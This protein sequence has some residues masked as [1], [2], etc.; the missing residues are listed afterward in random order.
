MNER[1][2]KIVSIAVIGLI[3]IGVAVAVGFA[4]RGGSSPSP[5]ASSTSW[6]QAAA[7]PDSNS[8]DFK[9]GSSF[10]LEQT[11]F[12]FEGNFQ[13][14]D[15]AHDKRKITLSVFDE[16]SAAEVSWEL[17]QLVLT[18][19][20]KAAEKT[21]EE[22]GKQGAAPQ[23]KYGQLDY[24]GTLSRISLGSTHMIGSPFIW[25][26]GNPVESKT[27]EVW[28]SSD[29]Y[30]ELSRTRSSTVYMNALDAA[31]SVA[32]GNDAMLKLIGEIRTRAQIVGTRTD[33]YLM[34]ASEAR[35]DY[36]VK[37]NGADTTVKAIKAKNWY[38]EMLVLDNPKNPLVLSFTFDPDLQGVQ[39]SQDN[40]NLLKGLLSYKIVEINP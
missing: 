31:R 11:V 38:G 15:P 7:K 4:K 6:G 26:F 9:V 5:S 25:A 19:E 3:V 13:T 22:G 36:P 34:K 1:V 30:G 21:W 18:D 14:V 27:S 32:S 16:G 40:V 37:L 29:V 28:V 20:S 39:A 17:R 24:G 2:K 10:V 12:L 8:T 35:V 33:V 23:P